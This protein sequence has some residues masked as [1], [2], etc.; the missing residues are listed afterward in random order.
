MV[1]GYVC[2]N[3]RAYHAIHEPMWELLLSY[4]SVEAQGI[5]RGSTRTS[6]SDI[7]GTWRGFH[8]ARL[9]DPLHDEDER[10]RRNQCR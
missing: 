1:A 2:A 3:R 5:F 6:L 9:T 8:L 10:I 7:E 4:K